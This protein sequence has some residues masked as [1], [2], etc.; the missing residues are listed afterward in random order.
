MRSLYVSATGAEDAALIS[1]LEEQG[2]AHG[3]QPRFAKLM[4]IQGKMLERLR[5]ARP[6]LPT[7]KTCSSVE[8]VS[9]PIRNARCVPVVLTWKQTRLHPPA[10]RRPPPAAR[11]P[12]PDARAAG[13]EDDISSR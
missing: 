1:Q 10:A 6:D 9:G 4:E 11:R 13:C 3:P 7:D 8:E 2:R 12:P 5:K